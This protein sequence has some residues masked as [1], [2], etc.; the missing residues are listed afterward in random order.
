MRAAIWI[1]VGTLMA[2][3]RKLSTAKYRLKSIVSSSFFR[4]FSV[5]GYILSLE[6]FLWHHL[7]LMPKLRRKLM[8]LLSSNSARF[9]YVQ[10][11]MIRVK[12]KQDIASIRTTYE[13]KWRSI[14]LLL[15]FLF[16]IPIIIFYTCISHWCFVKTAIIIYVIHMKTYHMY[17][18]PLSSAFNFPKWVDCSDTKLPNFWQLV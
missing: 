4:A 3:A 6:I 9:R 18:H 16:W 12:S 5:C 1:Q 7:I 11:M 17:H 8:Q 10:K 2:C 15:L 14:V 13:Y